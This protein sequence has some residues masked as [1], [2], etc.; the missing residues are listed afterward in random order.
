MM[1]F[2]P[3]H[4]QGQRPASY[5]PSATRWVNRPIQIKP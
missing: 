1:P 3:P 5:Q 2:R 4:P